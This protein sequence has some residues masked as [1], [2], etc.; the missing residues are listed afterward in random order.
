MSDM[1]SWDKFL[2][3][4]ISYWE[5]ISLGNLFS[6]RQETDRPNLRLLS[7]TGTDGIVE[8]DT[9]ERRDTS[10]SD[11]SKYLRVAPGDIA[12][13]T[14][15]MWQGVSGRSTKEGIV[16]PAYTVLNPSEKI[17]SKYAAYLLKLPLLIQK[18]HQNS[19]GLVDDTLNL[20]FQ[21]FSRI[22]V[23]IPQ[24]REQQKIAE[25]LTSV[26]EVIEN[27]QSQINKLEDLKKATM[28][29]LLTKGIGHTEF[30][31][32]EIG[33]IPRIWEVETLGELFDLRNGLNTTRDSFGQGVKFLTYKNVYQDHELTH[34]LITEKVTV[35]SEQLRA[36]SVQFG[37]V[38]FTRTSET[39]DEI[40]L[41]N[42]YLG[43]KIDAA[44]NGFCIRARPLS[45]KLIPGF[46]RFLLRADKVRTQI[47]LQSKYTTRA[48]IS[49]ESLGRC[50]LPIPHHS[51]QEAIA[52]SIRSIETEI[53]RLSNRNTA[54]Q[55]L[56][57]SLMQ[58]LLTGKVRVSVN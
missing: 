35:T 22:V 30:K 58:D 27:T 33:R 51:E 7:V 32:T 31:D 17:E 36:F 34:N 24:K 40:G 12:Y 52:D 5:N 14:M 25:I 2:D 13:N 23:K 50:I 48:G 19:Q 39:L 53:H 57:K 16:S 43:E 54:T 28:N 21:N 15:R 4:A 6:E 55:F 38:F 3:Q 9:L 44:F 29:E 18:F 47:K 41:A 56:K 37:D 11:K 10:N 1:N 46:C 49:G 45:E 20:K 26:D 8:R 42:V